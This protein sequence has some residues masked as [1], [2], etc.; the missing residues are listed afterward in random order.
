MNLLNS[1][2]FELP[3]KIVYGVGVT[4]RLVD[5]IKDEKWKRLVLVS[6]EGVVRSGLLQQVYDLLEAH[7]LKWT[8]FDRVEPNPKD[9]NVQE[10]T[11]MARQFGADALVA[12]GGGSPIDC[13]KAIA[14]VSRQGGAVRDY[15]GPGKIGP[16]VLPLIAIPTTA[17]TGSEVT[18]SSVITDSSDKYKFSI[19]DARIAPQVA[20]VDPEMT[21]TMPP[22]LTAA[23]G[24]D[25]LTHAIEAFTAKA[26][27]PLADAAALY[28]TELITAHL[29]NAVI[30]GDDLEARA[31][32]LLGSVLAG[33]AFS[34]SD[35]AAVHCVAEALGGK[36]DAAHGVCNAVVLPAVMEYNM[37]YCK[38]RYARIAGAM[39]LTYEDVDD[40][41]R[42]AVRAVQQLAADVQLPEFSSLGVQKGDIEEL[43]VNSFKNG[44]NIDNPRPMA[45]DDYL[46]LF[47][48]LIG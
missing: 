31:G 14:V 4:K 48:R 40:G 37:E 44:S 3:T 32:M 41:A 2:S 28:A 30:R 11:E 45:K 33:I 39:G 7:Q 29:R 20:L 17:G 16:D 38:E 13:A 22:E 35:V 21:L 10:G 34:H 18:F 42:Q 8:L 1:F 25:A 36:Y 24:M 6:D 12:I 26:S 9:Y 15:E 23:T 46:S 47:Q 27:E 19:K 43:A 5:V